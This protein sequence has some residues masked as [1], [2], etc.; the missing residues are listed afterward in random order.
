[1]SLPQEKKKYTYADYLAWPEEEKFELIDG[2]PYMQA[3]PSWQ[4]QSI[5]TELITQFSNY[6]KNK[7]CRV[8]HA[9]F[10]LRLPDENENDNET[11]TVVQPDIVVICDK[12]GLKDTGYYGTPPLIIEILSPSTA[13]KDKLYKLNK[14][15]ATGV[16]EYWMIEPDLKLV[17]VFK[18]QEN[19]KYGRPE[20][21]TEEDFIE[22]SIFS[23][24]IIDL[25]LVFASI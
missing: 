18:L 13:R 23:D 7:P 3:V 11:T 25:N 14:Y 20:M 6:L 9:P 2:I 17:S 4:H 8:F 22:V 12:K 24:L 16:K 5:S 19:K 1:M 10:D 21:Y 15:E